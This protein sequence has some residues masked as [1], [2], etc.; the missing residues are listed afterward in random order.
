MPTFSSSVGRCAPPPLLRPAA[1]SLTQACRDLP[2]MDTCATVVLVFVVCLV[3]VSLG[4]IRPALW[5]V[6]QLPGLISVS[7]RRARHCRHSA[8]VAAWPY[9]I[10]SCLAG[11]GL[12]LASFG[13]S[14][15]VRYFLR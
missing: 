3:A 14:G 5:W 8:A 4:S 13:W 6:L 7:Q 2:P 15:G 12:G 1:F 11:A 10:S 9:P